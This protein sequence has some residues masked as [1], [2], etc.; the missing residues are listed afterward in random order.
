MTQPLK[1]AFFGSPAFALPVLEA[2][3]AHFE[4][5]LVVAQPD[6][7]AGRGNKLTSPAVVTYAREH[8]LA[9]AQP[10]KLRKNL[11]FAEI[12]RSSGAD[13]AV[14]CAYGKILPAALLEV[15]THGFLNTHTSLLPLYRGAAPI[16]WALISGETRTGTTI[17]QTDPGMDTG[18]IILQES[19]EILPHWTALELSDAL[20]TQAARLIVQALENVET[21]ERTIQDDS[22]ATSAPMLEKEDGLVRWTDSSAVIY[23]RYRGVF[24]WPGTY[25]FLEGRRLKVLR[26]RPSAGSGHVGKIL[27]LSENGILVG[28][29]SGAI[30]LLEVQPENKGKMSAL[31]WFRGFQVA[32]GQHFK[33]QKET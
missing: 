28:C 29:G 11:E 19:L 21:L 31:E 17:M 33:N 2:I 5:I 16:Q 10:E 24:A 26:M 22:K 13:V 30:E 25:S 20:A 3:L 32:V 23:N 15:P 8:G 18:P 14:T 1:V 27:G 4:V 6:K 7:P 9:L 12:L